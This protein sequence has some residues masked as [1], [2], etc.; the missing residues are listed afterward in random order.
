MTI[1]CRREGGDGGPQENGQDGG[2]RGPP[3]RGNPRFRRPMR[4]KQNGNANGV[5]VRIF[6]YFDC[7]WSLAVDSKCVSSVGWTNCNSNCF[8][9]FAGWWSAIT[10]YNN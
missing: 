6:N 9:H 10:K 5:E 2:G 7:G 8:P 1:R 4:R 3:R